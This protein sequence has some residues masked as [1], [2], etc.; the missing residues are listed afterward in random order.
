LSPED[1]L[2]R[3]AAVEFV[4]IQII[5]IPFIT[6]FI[7]FCGKAYRDNKNGNAMSAGFWLL[8]VLIFLH[9]SGLIVILFEYLDRNAAWA[10]IVGIVY[11]F[12]GFIQYIVR[13]RYSN[14]ALKIGSKE[15]SVYVQS[16]IWNSINFIFALAFICGGAAFAFTRNNFSTYAA[17]SIVVACLVLMLFTATLAL[18]VKDRT[19]MDE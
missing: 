15:I 7:T 1:L 6:A 3:D 10:C 16:R 12:Y 2:Q 13:V 18:F 8:L 4:I 19:K 5:I 17:V 9:A 11:C 14:R